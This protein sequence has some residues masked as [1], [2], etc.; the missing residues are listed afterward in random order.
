VEELTVILKKAG[1]TDIVI[2]DKENS[3]EIVK[4]WNFGEGVEKMVFSAYVKAR[5]PFNEEIS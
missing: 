2:D 5:K 3:E 1:F 4:G